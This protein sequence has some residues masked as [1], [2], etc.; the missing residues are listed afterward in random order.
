MIVVVPVDPPRAGLVCPELVAQTPLSPTDAAY[1]YEAATI[2]VLRSVRASGGDLLIN[3]R[4][5]E[6]LPGLGVAEDKSESEYAHEGEPDGPD[7]DLPADPEA[8]IRALAARALE[9]TDDIRFERQVGST[10]AARIG[11]T[12]THLLEQEE[13][14]SV[15]VLE[16]T[17]A[18]IERTHIDGAAMSIRRNDV[19]LGP[20][21]SG[22]A[23]F[24]VFSEPIDFTD[25]DTTPELATLAG[26]CEDAGL[27]VGLAPMLP[28]VASE[29]GLCSTIALCEARRVA[30][31]GGLE[32]TA[33][34]IDEL[35]LVVRDG[36]GKPCVRL[37]S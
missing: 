28:T 20:G 8:E 11:N 18:G 3:Y 34:A 10:R 4:D 25:S 24:T 21:P 7:G 22:S 6:T 12:V 23:Y 1:L 31:R 14:A 16:P 37:E 36:D 30:G 2:D 35:G 26:R 15:G 17:A 9:G 5:A 13:A 29:T 27:E 33:T 19:I 32:A